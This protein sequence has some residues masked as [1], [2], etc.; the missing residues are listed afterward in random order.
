[1]KPTYRPFKKSDES[2]ISELIFNLYEEDPNYKKVSPEKIKKTFEMLRTQPE[3]GNIL[4]MELKQ[5]IIGYAI[6]INYWSNEFGGNILNID[7]LF[8][9]KEYRAQGIGTDFIKYL[10]QSKFGESVALELE[11]TPE[12]TP[13]LRLYKRLGFKVYKNQILDL[14]L[15]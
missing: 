3:R 15:K 6:L 11:V 13:A 8:I 14:E 10:A 9:K 4:V 2:A 5:E 1:M 12:N 7:E